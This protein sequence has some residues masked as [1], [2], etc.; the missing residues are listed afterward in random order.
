MWMKGLGVLCSGR[1]LKLPVS[2]K[3]A[4]AVRRASCDGASSNAKHMDQPDYP[5]PASVAAVTHKVG[6]LTA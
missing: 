4:P 5:R 6:W 3:A 1:S 2:F